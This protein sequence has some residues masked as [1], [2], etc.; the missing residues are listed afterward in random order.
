[1]LESS[2]A[3]S[4]RPLTANFDD[5]GD[6]P[7][8]V[9]VPADLPCVVS[10]SGNIVTKVSASIPL[11]KHVDSLS[12]VSADLPWNVSADVPDDLLLGFLSL[13]PF[14]LPA[15]ISP[16]VSV[17]N[18]DGSLFRILATDSVAFSS[19]V[20]VVES[21]KFSVVALGDVSDDNGSKVGV[22]IEDPGD[23][24]SEVSDSEVFVLIRETIDSLVWV[25]N[26]ISIVLTGNAAID[27]LADSPVVVLSKASVDIP[28]EVLVDKL[29]DSLD[30]VWNKA[31]VSREVSIVKTSDSLFGFPSKVSV[32]VP[33]EVIVNEPNDPLVCGQ[34]EIPPNDSPVDVIWAN[35]STDNKLAGWP[36]G[37]PGSCD[38][39]E[40]AAAPTDLEHQW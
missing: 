8:G 35:V 15:S 20:L 9:S 11:D 14:K 23:V 28:G 4:V 2:S 40:D 38:W 29:I 26:K 16:D 36:S 12:C 31:S 25:L 1:L 24:R 5:A 6:S 19:D 34:T 32:D 3:L 18:P 27:E 17:N 21:V 13:L 37:E 39:I 7:S 22:F 30:G 10:A 33:G